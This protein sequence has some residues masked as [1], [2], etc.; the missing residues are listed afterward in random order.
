MITDHE[1][2]CGYHHLTK[3]S[4]GNGQRSMVRPKVIENRDRKYRYGYSKKGMR[5]NNQL[6]CVFEVRLS[7]FKTADKNYLVC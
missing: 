3:P 2:Q 4:K 5:A 1:D 6:K 7:N